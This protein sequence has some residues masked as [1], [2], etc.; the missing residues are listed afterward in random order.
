[1]T[2]KAIKELYDIIKAPDWT[3][4]CPEKKRAVLLDSWVQR[5]LIEEEVSQS[6]VDKKYLNSEHLDDIKYKLGQDLSQLLTEDCVEFKTN[7]RQVSAKMIGLRRK[8]NEA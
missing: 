1:M 6:V 8:A 3:D 4:F 5:W 7:E 2:H